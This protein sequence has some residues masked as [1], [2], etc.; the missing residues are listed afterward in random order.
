MVAA[1]VAALLT[2]TLV[3]AQA[4]AARAPSR[5]GVQLP[6]LQKDKPVPGTESTA[7]FKLPVAPG[8]QVEYAPTRTTPVDGGSGQIVIGAGNGARQAS[9]SAPGGGSAAMQRAGNLPIWLGPAGGSPASGS[10]AAKSA[11]A[12]TDATAADT[13]SGTWTVTVSTRAA[14]EAAGL[15]GVLMK[16]EPSAGATAVDLKLKYDAFEQLYGAG[17]GSRLKL[18]QFPECFLTTPDAPG[19]SDAVELGSV[20]NGVLNEVTATVAPPAPAA[21]GVAAMAAS[22]G[23]SVV[24][25]ATGGKSGDAGDYQATSLQPS[26]KWTAG[27]S[28]GGFSWDYGIDV[29]PVAAGPKPAVSLGYS[30]QSVDGRTSTTNNQ[31]SWVGDGWDYHPGYIER[32]YRGCSDDKTNGNNAKDTGDLCWGSENAVMSLNGSTLPLVKDKTTKA[33][34]PTSDNGTRVEQKFGAV[35]GDD[36]GEYWLVTTPDGSKYHF[37]LNRLPGWANGK[38]TTDSVFTVPVFGN[39]SDEPCHQTAFENSACDQAWRWNLDYVEDTHSNAMALYWKQEKNWYAKNSKT[40]QPK[41][42]V[43]GGWL[44][45]I[46]YGLR[47]DAVYSRP[48]PAKVSFTVGERCLVSE[49]FDCADAK[50]T[51]FSTDALHWPDTPV[52]A[53]CK[54][55]GKCYTGGP[56][57]WSRKWL[58]TI[59]T[60]VAKSAGSNQYRPVDVFE[61]KHN[62]LD[63][64]YDT[65]PPAW[66]DSIRRTGHASD[67]TVA[68]LPP[69][70]FHANAVDMPNRQSKQG[71]ARPPFNRLR[72]EKI[73]TETGGGLVVKYSAPDPACTPGATKPEPQ[74][75][76]S[77]CYPVF[78]SP[79][80]ADDPK[81]E[82]FNK[83]VVDNI[84]EEDYVGGAPAKVT[85]YRY[86]DGAAWAKDDGEF[87]KAAER[88]W[89]LWRGY[90]RVQ[91]VTGKTSSDE[92]TVAGLSETRFFRGMH[93]D[94]LPSGTRVAQ[95]K[96]STG[97]VIADDLP[98]YQGQTAETIKYQA[99]GQ[100]VASRTVTVPWSRKTGTQPRTDAPA[101]DMYQGSIASTTNYETVSGGRVRSTGSRTL[102]F[103]PV[104]GLPLRVETTGDT[105]VQGDETCT[106]TTYLHNLSANLIG[107]ADRIRSFAS[108]CA[109]IDTAGPTRVMSDARTAYDGADYGVAPTRGSPTRTETTSTD[110]TGRIE[111]SRTEYDALGRVTKSFDA[112]GQPTTTAYTPEGNDSP[113]SAVVTNALGHA[114]TTTFE[115]GRGHALD[116]TD[117]NTRV[118]VSG[119]DPLG[120]LVKVWMPERSSGNRS[121]SIEYSY[122]VTGTEASVVTS[123][124]VR[125]DGSYSVGKTFYDGL[126]RQRQTQNEAIGAGRV[127]TDVMY[128]P[129]GDVRRENAKYLVSGEPS[130]KVY[131]PTSWTQIP[132]WTEKKYDGLGRATT[133]E[134]WNAGVRANTTRFEFGGDYTIEIPPTGGIASRQW[135]DALGRIVKRD[136]FT[137]TTRTQ[138]S[139]TKYEY[140]LRGN[141]SR[142]TDALGNEW[143]YK[144]DS[145]TRLIETNDPDKGR[146]TFTYDNLGQKTSSTDA[147]GVVL[148]R[149]YDAIGR[150][151]TIRTGTPNGPIVSE[152]AYDGPGAKGLL[153]KATQYTN[154]QPYS[155]EIGGYDLA[156]RVTGRTIK[157]PAT[158]GKLAGDYRYGYTYTDTGAPKEVV[159]PAAGGLPQEKLVFRYNA[160]GMPVSTS[161]LAWY[162]SDTTYD[163]FGNV[164]RSAA[165]SAPNRLWT[166]N[167]YDEA[168]GALKQ[169]A[170]HIEAPGHWLGDTSY[171]YDKAGNVTYLKDRRPGG[172]SGS[173][174]ED[175]QCFNYSPLRFLTE[176]W[177]STN[178]CATGPTRGP[179]G[180]VGGPDPYYREYSYDAI[181]NRVGE[182]RF[183]VT[184]DTAKDVTR[185]YAYAQQG[186]GRNHALLSVTTTA[187]QP[188]QQQDTYTY[189]ALG[190]TET[191]RVNGATQTLAWDQ[192]GKLSKVVDSVQGTS[193]FAYDVD[194][195]RL[196]RRTP[197]GS[198]L[199]LGDTEVT[200]KPDG[201]VAGLR[202]YSQQGAHTV[203]RSTGPTGGLTA[204]VTDHHQSSLIA[205]ALKPGMPVERRK[206]TAFG[207]TRGAAPANWVDRKGFVGGEVDDTTGLTLLGARMYDPSLGRF[208]SVDPVIDTGDPL[209]LHPYIYGYNNPLYYS[210]PSGLWG[211][212]KWAKKTVKAV[213]KVAPVVHVVLDVA[214]MVPVIGEAADLANAG[215]YAAEGDWVNAAISAAGAIPIAGNAATTYRVADNATDAVAVAAKK[216]PPPTP[217]MMPKKFVRPNPR[218]F[219]DADREEKQKK[220]ADEYIWLFHA[221]TER[222]LDNIL[223]NGI[224]PQFKTRERDFGDGFYVTNDKTQADNWARKLARS[225][226]RG[227][228]LMYRV[229]KSELETYTH[230]TYPKSGGPA[231]EDTVKKGRSGRSTG[232][233]D[234][235]EG[236]MLMNPDGYKDYG[237]RP[238]V[239]GHQIAVLTAILAMIFNRWFAGFYFV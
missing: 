169:T 36:N 18:V 3:P 107:T 130:D 207:E 48:A 70:T 78:W 85:G 59:T 38:A 19:C 2:V 99:D 72:V 51:K 168:T 201:S 68:S 34:K 134:T 93:G 87:T 187:A 8:T 124:T 152:W 57:F 112:N 56:T 233:Y 195:N 71:E 20:N 29:P 171:G 208:I 204:M 115:P 81:I 150:Q 82:W 196:I 144:Y 97:A 40:D 155:E 203:V 15:D 234:Y 128:N 4:M 140:D 25:A 198:T 74:A 136:L 190:N 125:D 60:E 159:L 53:M 224:D 216:A 154:G 30:S 62:F 33:W 27:G 182:K 23:G 238:V 236:P 14:T 86:L 65:N 162:T 41:P 76:T 153:S 225:G 114:T 194:G 13:P 47:T 98:P 55:T 108:V 69:V 158:E 132:S 5:S 127:V 237:E 165:G 167:T 79:D 148:V 92:G 24:L 26:G 209:Q 191:R 91:V 156:Y 185:S 172:T 175:V 101:L 94:P 217:K 117:P 149:A 37:G 229:K 46:E 116:K 223:K 145:R 102:E 214:G 7:E 231:W 202:Y 173:T 83:Y 50:F 105:T 42:Y 181:G 44:D 120:R 90:G 21:P 160:D 220:D 199:F 121:P 63:A 119:Y 133:A 96:D 84:S 161:G 113:T 77:R 147:R 232:N 73:F 110:G 142:M 9:G 213:Q 129:S 215:L 12:S 104:H 141:P 17:W 176:T 95:V 6:E 16:L 193:E 103:D 106:V 143:T 151:T 67:G 206:M 227:V 32:T 45:R 137:D 22:S 122:S 230:V 111:D 221:T 222:S 235:I 189:D 66:L 226:D 54:D 218:K 88:T 126:L 123:R 197:T 180:T 100:A 28:S 89:S 177:T 139:E 219:E 192:H 52:D 64:R 135:T 163:A 186:P 200:A 166:T 39:Q 31:A 75:N 131:A 183:D 184:G 211:M 178:Q 109:D 157:I 138:F 146:S 239:K 205:V 118:T 35:N 1:S 49:T 228:V 212:P 58:T 164:L 80:S 179:G 11:A 10:S 188:S 43:R 174:V 61:L 170:N 210:D